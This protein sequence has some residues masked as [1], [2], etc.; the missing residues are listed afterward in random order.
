MGAHALSNGAHGLKGEIRIFAAAEIVTMDPRR[1]NATHVAVCDGRILGVGPLE[2]LEVWGPYVLDDTFKEHVLVPGMIEAHSHVIEGALWE[3][4]YV[5]FHPR[6]G[7]AGQIEGGQRSVDELLA[8]LL[9]EDSRLT[10]PLEPLIC[11]GLDPLYFPGERLT[12]QHLDMVSPTRQIIV[13][14][15]SLHLAT[16]NTATLRA[17][18][19]D[20][21]SETEGILRDEFGQVV[22]ELQEFPAMLTVRAIAQLF[23]DFSDPRHLWTL[24]RQGVNAGITTLTNLAG[25]EINDPQVV[26]AIALQVTEDSFPI[27]LVT[28]CLAGNAA[29][30]VIVDRIKELQA[31]NTDKL[32]YGGIKIVGDGSIQG[33][34]AVMNWP[35]YINDAPQGLWQVDPDRLKE[36]VRVLHAAGINLHLH[37]N[38]DATIDA[39]IDAVDHALR[40]HAWLNHRHT[41]QHSQITTPAHYRT[42]ARLGMCANIFTN[43]LWYWGD[44]HYTSTLGPDR[45][46]N[47]E[48]C[49]TAAREGVRFSIHSDAPVTP[50]NQLH[51]M[52]CAINRTTPT[53]RTLGPHETITAYQALAAVT[54]DAA[55]QLHLDHKIGSIETGKHADFTVL[56]TNPLTCDPH[57]IRDI[58]IWGTILAGTPHP[59]N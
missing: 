54:I 59:A 10:D 34:T 24:A 42:M 19:I 18:G 27:R 21:I 28:Y 9:L 14:H 26:P 57:H 8:R 39:V 58:N 12:A 6:R 41:L 56:T 45:T 38:G 37:A 51:T 17:N 4:P 49:A 33:Y 1:P 44:Q 40:N 29:P 46:H 48:T 15:A 55:Y 5:G 20:A 32:I 7:P 30:E 53:G 23:R 13:L 50:L 47:M 22:G 16:V 2:E 31:S 36:L 43:H 35:G 11:W 25:S 52:W 3:R